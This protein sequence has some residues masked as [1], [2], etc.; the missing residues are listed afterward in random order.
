MLKRA[1]AAAPRRRT[2]RVLPFS[3]AGGML[4]L[5]VLINLL[6][7]MDRQVLSAVVGPIKASFLGSRRGWCAARHLTAV[8]DWCQQRLGFKPEDALVGLL[9][10]AF[11]V[12]YMIG[13]PV[14]ARLAERT[15]RW[16]L[17]GIGVILWSLAS[18]ASG[19]AATFV[20][21]LL[22]RCLVGV[23]EAAYG[24]VAPVIISDLY[25]VQVRGQVLAWFYMAIPVGSALGYVLG[26]WVASSGLGEW[27]ASA[28]GTRPGKL[29]MGLLPRRAAGNRARIVELLHARSA[30]RAGG[31]QARAR[32]R[33][34][35]GATTWFSCARLR[36]CCARLA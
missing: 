22:T 2:P 10:T 34:F 25:P 7:Y 31:S 4:A 35:A 11:M 28:L 26:G 13:A 5:L 12:V 9:G 30:A 6:N 8:M 20:A 14:F 21:L 16:M 36:T 18:G 33:R 19:M 32:A 1:A 3:G 15:S 24:P 29:A 23:G 27:G 17:I